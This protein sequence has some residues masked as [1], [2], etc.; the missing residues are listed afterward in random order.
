MGFDEA[1][2]EHPAAEF[3]IAQDFL[4]VGRSG[5]H[6]LQAHVIQRTQA[7]I[8]RLFPGQCPHDQLQAHR[9]VIRRNGVAGV[10][11]RVGTHAG[12]AGRVVAGDLAEAG[13][14]VVLRIFR[15]DAELDGEAAMD[16]VFLLERQRLAGSNADLLAHDVDA[17]DFLG[18]GVFHLHAG[19]HLHEVH[20]AI[21][22]QELHGTGVLVTHGLGGLHR[23]L[24]D[25][26]ALLGGELRAGGDLDQLLVAALDRAVTLEQVHGVA[27]TV[28]DDLRFDVLRVDDALLEEHLGAAEGL[29]GFGDHARVVQL[30]F[31]TAVAATDTTAA[32]TGGGLEHH[33]ITDAV[34]LAQR[35]FQIGHVAFGTRS[36]GYA[37][38]DHGAAR[39]GLV[40]HAANDVSLWP[41]E[42]DPAFGADFR[43]FR[44]FRQEAIAG[45]QGITAGFHRKV[46]QLA[47]V[48]VAGQRVVAEAVGLVGALHMQGVAV[49]VGVHRHR[50]D[51]HLGAGTHDAHCNFA[52]VGDKDFLDHGGLPR[53]GLTDRKDP[54]TGIATLRLRMD[55]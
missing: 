49:G 28:G 29:G 16:H 15:V 37:G 51:A 9:V 43:Q 53:L 18:D 6:P 2:V 22:E 19:V 25:I 31:F 4:I 1:G 32:T 14:E 34:T 11:R 38:G 48:E 41:D 45:M 36:A 27:M 46:H 21:G 54:A 50:A 26:G 17:G 13:Q 47:R 39:F 12:A 35:L 10:D 8:H 40:A 24:A 30:Q 7:A 55:Q 3:R 33:R 52:T 20:H 44:V 42:L 23:Q 5:L